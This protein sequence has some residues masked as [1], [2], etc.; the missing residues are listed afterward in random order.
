MQ[1]SAG[2]WEPEYDT[3]IEIEPG[4]TVEIDLDASNEPAVLRVTRVDDEDAEFEA[5][6]ITVSHPVDFYAFT[7]STECQTDWLDLR[8]NAITELMATRFASV[9]QTEGSPGW[10]AMGYDYV[11][12]HIGDLTYEEAIAVGGSLA[13]TMEQIMSSDSFRAFFAQ[14]IG[15]R[16][17]A[18]APLHASL[19]LSSRE[20]RDAVK[21][22]S[23]AQPVTD[24]VACAIAMAA[25]GAGRPALTKLASSLYVRFDELMG[26]LNRA[27]ADVQDWHEA[28]ELIALSDWATAR[29]TILERA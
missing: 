9:G 26:E 16:V 6:R 2:N 4:T 24:T 18:D 29:H 10:T 8:E 11:A 12:G 7:P 3:P 1:S 25:A 28:A 27:R 14:W 19:A 23:A 5:Y 21:L 15:E 17:F 13:S 22:A 20:I